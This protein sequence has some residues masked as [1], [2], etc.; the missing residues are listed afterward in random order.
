MKHIGTKELETDR[1]L[2]RRISVDDAEKMYNNW[3]S[4]PE[5]SKYVTWPT[6]KDINV[7]KDLLKMWEAEYTNSSCYR[8]CVVLKENNEPIGTI[9]VVKSEDSYEIAEIGYCISKEYW[10][11]GIMTECAK[12]VLKFLF[13][14]VGYN[15]IQATHALENPASGRVMQKIGM[16]YEGTIRD[17][18]RLNQGKLCDV[19]MY[20]ILKRE[21]FK[22]EDK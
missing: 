9:D 5:V 18:N 7:T 13:E 8:W 10:G 4:D 2:L 14:E 12:R 20:S 19:A 21:Y 22:E 1:I 3:A 17:G 11:K 6:H 16:Q 15:R